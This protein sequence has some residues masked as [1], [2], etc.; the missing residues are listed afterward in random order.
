[1]SMWIMIMWTI[2]AVV[3]VSLFYSGARTANLLKIG[4]IEEW[5]GF[6]R[7][8]LGLLITLAAFGLMILCIDFVNAIVCAI[9]WAMIWAVC[10][11]AFW[12]FGKITRVK[13]KP[14][15]SAITAMVVCVSALS[16]CC[17]FYTSP[18]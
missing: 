3:S 16:S 12:L 6:K 8:S 18:Y 4:A 17:Y 5:G 2:I 9:Y 11:F 7:F 13:L 15:Y 14:R 10:D 1:M